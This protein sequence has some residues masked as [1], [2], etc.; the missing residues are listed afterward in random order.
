[1]YLIGGAVV[2][3]VHS[4]KAGLS[5][6]MPGTN[7]ASS[8]EVVK[9]VQNGSLDEK[10]LD[11][12]V[13]RILQIVLKTKENKKDIS[14][15]KEEQHKLAK[16]A[17]IESTVLLKNEDNILP[18][19]KQGKIAVIGEFAKTPRYQGS[20]SSRVN[21]TKIDAPYDEICK[22]C[23]EKAT[24]AFASGYNLTDDNINQ[25]IIGEAK[26]LAKQS[27]ITI[28][29]A[30]L[31]DVYESEGYDRNHMHIPENQIK[32]INELASVTKNIIVILMNGAPI[33]MPWIDKTKGVLEA[34]LGGQAVGSAIADI[35]FGEVSP[36]GKLAET[37]PIKLEDNPSYLNFP[38]EG[39]VVEYKEGLFV[40]YRYYDK[41]KLK[42]L[43]PFGFGLSYTNFDYKSIKVDKNELLDNESLNV[44]VS[45]KNTGSITAKEV[46]QLYV[47]DVCSSL[48]RPEKELKAFEKIELKP[49]EEKEITFTLNK[50]A[51]AYYNVDINDWYVE[52]GDFE[53][54]V[55]KSSEDILL[56]EKV[57]VK[58]TTSLKKTYTLNSLLGDILNDQRGKDVLAD[59]AFA[60]ALG[61]FGKIDELDAT[62]LSFI[63]GFPLRTIIGFSQG[64]MTEEMLENLLNK[65]N[66]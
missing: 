62:M 58:S 7:G 4:I 6:E 2:N 15:S 46:V 45:I 44:T 26:E 59:K 43:F 54:L 51:F 18:L 61:M 28:L 10:T 63:Y 50:R 9:A 27:D 56:K 65:L 12:A 22:T 34:Y 32:L 57:I 60:D 64:K 24:V 16:Q 55:G 14:Y 17:S 47:R 53:I 48:I 11:E 3:L 39:D 23:E 52:D 30:G 38:G 66:N 5:L 40:G 33:E 35:L 36:S 1:M 49:N 19:K 13:K 8:A 21:A 25:N 29:F 31:P 20:G 41:K 42:P 37:F